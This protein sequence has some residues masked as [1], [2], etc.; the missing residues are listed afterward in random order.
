MN[1]VT[2][3][4]DH[5]LLTPLDHFKVVSFPELTQIFGLNVAIVGTTKCYRHRGYRLVIICYEA[6]RDDM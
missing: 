1:W 3:F 2:C 6:R 4:P 5:R